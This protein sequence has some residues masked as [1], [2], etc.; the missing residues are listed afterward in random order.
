MMRGSSGGGLPIAID[1]AYG[2]A[3]DGIR[4][5]RRSKR[6]QQG[7]DFGLR[8][9][10]LFTFHVR[11]KGDTLTLSDLGPANNADARQLVEGDYKGT[12]QKK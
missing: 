7:T 4:V 10:A 12:G 6:Q 8:V 2:M 11:V 5:G 1:A 3:K 9:G